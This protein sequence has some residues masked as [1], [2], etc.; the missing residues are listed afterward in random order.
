[1]ESDRERGITLT[2]FGSKLRFRNNT[3]VDDAGF[4][5]LTRA[6]FIAGK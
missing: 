3:G 6:E 4:G 2:V 1:M 5:D